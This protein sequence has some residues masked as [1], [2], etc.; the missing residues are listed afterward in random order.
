METQV[1]IPPRE[2]RITFLRSL[3]ERRIDTAIKHLEWVHR[4]RRKIRCR[5]LP[6][7]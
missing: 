6:F 1:A 5:I 2:R 3:H 7:A 4:T